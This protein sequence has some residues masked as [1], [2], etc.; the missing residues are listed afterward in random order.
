MFCA[1]GSTAPAVTFPVRIW[2]VPATRQRPPG[3]VSPA[4]Q[5]PSGVHT[6]ASPTSAPGTGIAW[7]TAVCATSEATSTE[8][9][10]VRRTMRP[11]GAERTVSIGDTFRCWP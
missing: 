5:V 1:A 7:S 6:A 4:G 8:T 9:M 3:H 10:V 11:D 2:T